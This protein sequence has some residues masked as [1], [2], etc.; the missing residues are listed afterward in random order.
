VVINVD[1]INIAINDVATSVTSTAR[2]GYSLVNQD[3]GLG[4]TYFNGSS[5]LYEAGLMIGNSVTQVS[6]MVRST[7]TTSDNDFGSVILVQKVLPAVTSDFDLVGYFND[8][9][10]GPNKMSVFVKHDSYAWTSAPNRKYILRKFTV[11]NNNVSPLSS[12]Y[13]GIFAD[14][15]VQNASFNKADYDSVNRMGYVYSTQASPIYC[16]IKLL[17]PSG[18]VVNSMDNLG[19]GGGGI[20]VTDG[21][22]TAEKYQSLSTNRF[23]AGNSAA[24]GNDVLQVVSAGPFNMAVDD[25]AVVVF[26][27][28]AGDN[29]LDIQS[30]AAAAQQKY[31]S[32]YA[33]GIPSLSAS[34]QEMLLFPNPAKEMVTIQVPSASKEAG[35]ISL[36]TLQGELIRS[37]RNSERKAGAQQSVQLN[38]SGLA[39]GMYLIKYQSQ[40]RSMT[41]KLIIGN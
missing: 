19:G 5:Q 24:A 2:I 39:K 36:L 25:S 29:L 35:T 17:S 10:A 28:I 7:A 9:N 21:Y 41:Q 40:S 13:A 27:M 1:Y 31:D 26:A 20:D 34:N 22:S 38:L 15:D 14:W 23:Q 12:I 37:I 18:L 33:V 8:D 11:Y 16:A 6:D 30:S 3:Q 4:F 32:L